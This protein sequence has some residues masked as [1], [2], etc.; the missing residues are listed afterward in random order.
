MLPTIKTAS[1]MVLLAV[2]SVASGQTVDPNEDSNRDT[3]RFTGDDLPNGT[4]F[5]MTLLQLDHF[6]TR[7]GPADAAAWVEQELGLSKFDS[8][9]F[10]SQALTTLYFID[11]D[12]KAQTVR[13]ACEFSG[14]G[15]DKTDQ[16]AA[17]QQMYDIHKAITDHYFDRTKANLDAETGERFQKWM[18]ERKLNIT[19]V[20]IDF[21]KSYQ[22]SGKDPAVT[23]SRLCEGDD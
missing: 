11:T 9:T 19:D 12:V 20:E 7:F 14:P 3:N 10:V 8:A 23:L 17:L 6:N 5:Y 2:T 4:A 1:I 22:K 18:D 21:E 15:V 13:L 16:Y